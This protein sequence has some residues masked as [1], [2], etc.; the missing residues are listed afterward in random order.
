[1][2][3]TKPIEL[4]P[5]AKR[6]IA[7]LGDAGYLMDAVRREMDTQ[8]QFTVDAIAEKRLSGKGPFPVEQH[9]LGERTHRLRPSL[10]RTNSVVTGGAVEGSIG[11]NVEY[12]GV[13][14][15]GFEGEVTVAGHARKRFAMQTFVGVGKR[16]PRRKVRK[17][18]V[19]VGAFKRH[20]KV[21][22]RAPITTGVEE[23]IPATGL[24]VSR[25]I[26]TAWEEANRQ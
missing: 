3:E 2:P 4:S 17:A 10:R 12:A 6:I 24:A 25:A 26:V 13:H 23:R 11:T 8:N 19:T 7:R 16:N 20:M 9:R 5:E 22:A 1:M 15:F 14:E 21:L 18:D